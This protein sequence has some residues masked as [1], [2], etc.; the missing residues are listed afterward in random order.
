M[1]PTDALGWLFV[2]R[3]A[4]SKQTM[5]IPTTAI[6][7]AIAERCHKRQ[8]RGQARTA[9]TTA[10][11]C[12]LLQA[13]YYENAENDIAQRAH[14]P[15]LVRGG[16]RPGAGDQCPLPLAALTRECTGLRANPR[17]KGKGGRP[18]GLGGRP[19]RPR[20]PAGPAGLGGRPEKGRTEEKT[21]I[22]LTNASLC[23]EEAST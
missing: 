7:S 1:L 19:G 23:C 20:R 5:A 14:W 13:T 10:R 16:T 6:R 15:A 8:L 21:L 18:A 2:T 9:P 17:G 22:K 11:Q 3:C 4:I 12:G